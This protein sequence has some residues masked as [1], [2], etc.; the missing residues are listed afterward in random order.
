MNGPA[1]VD[2]TRRLIEE[3]RAAMPDLALRT[4]LIVG[5]PGETEDEFRALLEF[6]R[7]IRFDRLGVFIYSPEP[8]TAAAALPDPVPDEIASDRR[9]LLM[10]AQQEISLALNQAQVGRTLDVL[11]EG[12]GGGLTIGRSYRDA[13]EI[14]GLVL[15]HG[16]IP[17]AAIGQV[18]AAEITGAM[19]YDLLGE[20]RKEKL[21]STPSTSQSTSSPISCSTSSAP[22]ACHRMRRASAPTS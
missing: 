2:R 7:H 21:C 20:I 15:V 9:E 12:Q 13:P 14:D 19:E 1:D 6:V 11:L 22:S 10:A 17:A 4:S 18:I 3:L 8:G 16:D 5:Y